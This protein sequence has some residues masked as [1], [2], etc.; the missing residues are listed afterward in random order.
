M[1]KLVFS[2]SITLWIYPFLVVRTSKSVSSRYFVIYTSLLLTIV[3]GMCTRTYSSSLI[4][5]LYSEPASSH[6]PCSSLSH[7]PGGSDGGPRSLPV[8]TPCLAVFWIKC[9][10]PLALGPQLYLPKYTI[11]QKI[12]DTKEY[13]WYDSIHVNFKNRQSY[14]HCRVVMVIMG[15]GEQL[16]GVSRSFSG[17]LCS[18]SWLEHKCVHF[19]KIN[20]F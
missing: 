1:I 11:E 9:L 3:T 8:W 2:I 18:V 17:W 7:H 6:P 14:Y 10:P 20:K 13:I 5:T 4:V 12:P 19:M 15:G 16:K